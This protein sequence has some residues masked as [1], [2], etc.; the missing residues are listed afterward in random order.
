MLGLLDEDWDYTNAEISLRSEGQDERTYAGL[1]VTI[2]ESVKCPSLKQQKSGSRL[3]NWYY[4]K[5]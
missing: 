4:E 2:D 1:P 5:L 3:G